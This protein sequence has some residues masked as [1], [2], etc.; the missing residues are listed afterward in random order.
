MS[1]HNFKYAVDSRNILGV[2]LA[3]QG[4]VD[5]SESYDML[6]K[7]TPLSYIICNGNDFIDAFKMLVEQ[8]ADINQLDGGG[9]APIH[10]AISHGATNILETMLA[11]GA[12]LSLQDKYGDNTLHWAVLFESE[13]T[14]TLLNRIFHSGIDINAKNRDMDTPLHIACF[15]R[16]L[17]LVKVLILHGANIHARDKHGRTPLYL[18]CDAQCPDTVKFLMSQ[19]ADMNVSDE[20]G[21]TPEDVA[22][23]ISSDEILDILKGAKKQ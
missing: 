22:R 23:R 11:L 20:W 8:G 4:G 1:I 14:D 2:A 21:E 13:C 6:N 19:G 7:H 10:Y 16:L 3:L 17:D 15:N 18:A 12:D 5:L 9:C